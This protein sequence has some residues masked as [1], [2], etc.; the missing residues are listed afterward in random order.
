LAL[1]VLNAILPSFAQN[2]YGWRIQTA[3]CTMV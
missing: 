3:C 1:M 2:G